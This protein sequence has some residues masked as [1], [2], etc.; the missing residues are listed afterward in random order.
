MEEPALPAEK[1]RPGLVRQAFQDQTGNAWVKVVFGTSKDPYNPS[2]TSFTVATLPEMN[3]CGLKCATRF[4][5]DRELT[6]PW[7]REFFECLP[8]KATPIIGHM[9]DYEIRKLQTQIAYLQQQ[10][11]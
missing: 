5:L 2:L 3:M 8:G 11:R 9:P 4:R 6:L 1:S 7:T 10:I